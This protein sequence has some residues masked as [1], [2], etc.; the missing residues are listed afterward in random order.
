MSA[1]IPGQVSEREIVEANYAVIAERDELR[2]QLAASQA[3]VAELKK[4]E[5][6]LVD[7]CKQLNRDKNTH[8]DQ[9]CKNLKR[10]EQAEAREAVLRECVELYGNRNHWKDWIRPQHTNVFVPDVHRHYTATDAGFAP[11]QAALAKV[12]ELKGGA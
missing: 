1:E 3:R 5:T 6:E 7:V 9:S 11:A 10:A 8:F 4:R 12:E 2:Q